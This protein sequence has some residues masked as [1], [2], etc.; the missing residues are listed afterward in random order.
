MKL[1]RFYLDGKEFTGTVDGESDKVRE[2]ESPFDHNE[3]GRE[4]KLSELK[5][6]PPVIPSKIVCVGLNYV[7]HA[8]ELGLE[9]P[10]AP[11]I[12][13][14]PP[15]ALVAHEDNIV[16]PKASTRVEYEGEL[17]IV[18]GEK[19]FDVKKAQA[20]AAILGYTA[21]NDITARDLQKKDGQWTRAKSFDTFAPMGPW[22]VTADEFDNVDSL[23]IRTFLNGEKRQDS[24]TKN[25]IFHVPEL[26]EFISGIMT[27]LP[28][29]IIA[30]GTPPG[31]G[32]IKPEDV[33]RVEIDGIGVLK[34]QVVVQNG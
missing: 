27:L 6:L 21:L 26:I 16:F 12:F 19:S 29:D 30:T 8:H 5:Y 11:L 32:Y 34:N 31:V 18:I 24:N 23:P 1:G 20:D 4:F 2:I 10:D 7:D 17:A 3:T 28:G 13:L 14:K 22:V 25:L 33:I 15:S 9:P